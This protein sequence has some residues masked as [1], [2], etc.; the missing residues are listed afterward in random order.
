MSRREEF[1]V[2]VAGYGP[3]G[4]AAT[5]LLA[6]SGHAVCAFER[7]PTLYGQPRM[8]TIDGET[9]R[10]IQAASDIES[11]LANSVA[12]PRYL[13]ANQFGQI[14]IDHDWDKNHVCGFPYRISLHQ[15]D[16]EDA[17]DNTARLAGAEINQ[18]WEVVSV[19]QDVDFVS[20]TAQERSVSAS[21]QVHR[22]KLRTIRARYLIAADGARSIVRESLGVERESWPFRG[23]WLT[24]DATRKRELPNFFGISPNGS[25]AVIFCAPEGLAH[26][27]IPL[28]TNHIR[29][30]FQTDPDT[31]GD[32]ELHLDVALPLLKSVYGITGDDVEVY[33]Q[34]VYTFEGKL[35]KTW[36]IG[37]I[38]LAGDAA[39]VMTP[40]Q[41]Q[42]GCSGL[43]DAINLT[44]KMD[45]VLKGAASDALLDTYEGERKADVR[46]YVEG[47]DSL[48]AMIF[49]R[50]PVA[51]AERDKRLISGQAANQSEQRAINS[52]ILY[53]VDDQPPQRPVGYLGPQGVV[54]SSGGEGRFDEIVGAGFQLIGWQVDPAE[55]LTA[56]QLEFLHSIG[57]VICGVT[58][59]EADNK[60]VIDVEGVY[61]GFCSNFGISGMIQRPDFVI[62][63]VIRDPQEF[64]SLVDDLRRQLTQAI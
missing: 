15:P 16:I 60:F 24:F 20:V 37:R 1:D 5:S 14:L 49:T 54:R 9:A 44:W 3:T 58:D 11:A 12:R 18:G 10:I 2:I 28:G 59:E 25:V 48:G 27:I 45:L 63:G 31:P 8:A 35:A 4:M 33:R 17:M 47:S 41:G 50:D 52:G 61:K 19:I 22:G 29:F 42:G 57:A 56:D 7:W 34:A 32:G 30:N 13:I 23:A 51:A 39:H 38:F 36:K 26:S 53:R 62:F 43:R 40:F 55:F 6:Q 46:A 64:S 21:G